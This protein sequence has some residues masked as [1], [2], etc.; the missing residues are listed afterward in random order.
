MGAT[1]PS[2]GDGHELVR[3]LEGRLPRRYG[4]PVVLGGQDYESRIR[5]FA[6]SYSD[7][8]RIPLSRNPDSFSISS[9]T[10]G[11]E[12]GSIAPGEDATE[13]ASFPL[14]V[15]TFFEPHSGQ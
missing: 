9:A 11:V 2:H 13:L 7:A 8:D 12:E 6:A 10:E 3:P 15:L 4:G 1:A 14:R 5:F